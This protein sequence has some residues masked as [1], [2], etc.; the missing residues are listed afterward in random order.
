MVREHQPRQSRE[1]EQYQE[2]WDEDRGLYRQP[3]GTTLH[4][5]AQARSDAQAQDEVKHKR[6]STSD[7]EVLQILRVRQRHGFCVQFGRQ[8]VIPRR[9]RSET[10]E[11]H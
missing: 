6:R 5:I 3:A 8:R 2:R 4:E 11:N 9:E 10:T 1:T 7:T